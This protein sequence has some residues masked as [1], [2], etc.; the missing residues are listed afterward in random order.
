MLSITVSVILPFVLIL[1]LAR[2]IRGTSS[3]PTI[4]SR[5]KPY[6]QKKGPRFFP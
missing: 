2:L 6:Q 3:A 1:A 4:L 5:E